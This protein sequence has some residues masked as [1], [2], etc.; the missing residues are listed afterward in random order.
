MDGVTA[1]EFITEEVA[2]TLTISQKL[3]TKLKQ[4]K[5]PTRKKRNTKR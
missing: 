3:V 1:V 4:G 2:N 5:M